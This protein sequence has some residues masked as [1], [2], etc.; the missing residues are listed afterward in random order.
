MEGICARVGR[1]EDSLGC[2]PEE[3]GVVLLETPS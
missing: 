2:H 3:L 1:P